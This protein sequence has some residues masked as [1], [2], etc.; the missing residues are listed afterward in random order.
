[1]VLFNLN[2]A[3]KCVTPTTANE[4]NSKSNQFVLLPDELESMTLLL[5]DYEDNG[6]IVESI[7]GVFKRYLEISGPDGKHSTIIAMERSRTLVS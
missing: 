2:N 1:M 4:P 3:L 7:Y 6:D 5:V